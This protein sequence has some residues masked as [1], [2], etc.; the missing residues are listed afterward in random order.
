[1]VGRTPSCCKLCCDLSSGA[2]DVGIIGVGGGVVVVVVVIVVAGGTGGGSE[3][4]PVM[5]HILPLRFLQ[6]WWYGWRCWCRR[7]WCCC[8]ILRRMGECT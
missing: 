8:S 4:D 5:L 7:C 6:F 3:P 1:M 2:D